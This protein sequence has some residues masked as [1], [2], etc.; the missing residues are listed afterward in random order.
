MQ[1]IETMTIGDGILTAGISAALGW[2]AS[3][4]TKVSKAEFKELAARVA[5]IEKD[6]ITRDEFEKGM[7]KLETLIKEFRVEMKSD[8]REIKAKV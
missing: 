6:R 7:G 8:I 5:S 1:R 4:F 2:L 3:S